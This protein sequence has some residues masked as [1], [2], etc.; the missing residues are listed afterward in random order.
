MAIKHCE[1][2]LS[3]LDKDWWSYA[4]DPGS[5]RYRQSCI[6]KDD[7]Q[8]LTVRS[9]W[10]LPLDHAM[11]APR[12][13]TQFGPNEGTPLKVGNALY[14]V[15][16]PS[17]VARFDLD[18]MQAAKTANGDPIV[19]D[20]ELYREAAPHMI[21]FV[22]RGLTYWKQG[23]LERIFL[24]C[25]DATLR[26]LDLDLRP[27]E[28]FGNKGTVDVAPNPAPRLL[29]MTSPPAVCGDVVIVG[30]AIGD[31]NQ[32]HAPARG[33]VR[34]YHA[35]SGA[36]LWT[37]E[38]IPS[39]DTILGQSI[40]SDWGAGSNRRNGHANVWAPMS[41]D[42]DAGLVYLP[43]SSAYN[44]A[45]GGDRPGDNRHSQSI[46]ALDVKTGQV[47]W[48]FQFI[49][50]DLCDYDPPAAPVLIDVTDNGTVHKLVVQVTKQAFAYVLDRHT[51]EPRWP[52]IDR[53]V[54]RS[55]IP[56][57]CA[58]ATQPIPTIPKPF[59][60]QGLYVEKGLDAHGE[61]IEPN[62]NSLSETLR[63]QILEVLQSYQH[64][65]LFTPPTERTQ[66]NGGTI[67]F[68]G[69]LGGASWAGAV[70]DPV[71]QCMY[72]SSIT[73]ANVNA[74]E[75]DA[76]S[77]TWFTAGYKSWT[78]RDSKGEPFP[79]PLLQPP[80]GRITAIDLVSGEH[81]WQ[82][83]VGEGP[84]QALAQA[85]DDINLPDGELGWP[86]RVH[87]LGTPHVLFAA[88]EADRKPTGLNVESHVVQYS[89]E[90]DKPE[91]R[92]YDPDN[93]AL[94]TALNLPQHAQGALMHFSHKGREYIA[95]PTG[96]F[97][98]P[99]QIVIVGMGDA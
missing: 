46:V 68:P 52:I 34:A 3:K 31:L 88:Q 16:A 70:A 92:A 28:E 61:S 5:S 24:A 2:R 72:V 39:G 36:P 9:V 64:G 77:E 47:R 11:L 49:R 56:G 80:W 78:V 55:S 32:T 99:A 93:G 66:D 45:Y 73:R 10:D 35:V 42:E 19:Y 22:H 67:Q 29:T 96:G 75:L 98:L 51:G 58:C 79:Y 59:D 37:F 54:P 27:I 62:V 14:T 69:Y 48:E 23:Q 12:E 8:R 97:D 95:I 21:G 71:R 4:G 65:P 38:T 25:G 60:Q 74:V 13:T 91:L 83:P 87:L 86:R 41:V 85:F 81:L 43:V 26:A 94:L 6:G 15:C 50:H 33:D 84:R 40:E 44:D 7:V 76:E 53:P 63:E 90:P 57:E 20:P 89:F 18:S 17:I 82:Q 1:R 30:S